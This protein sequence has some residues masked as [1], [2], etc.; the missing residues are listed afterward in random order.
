[1]RRILLGPQHRQRR[2]SCCSAT[3]PPP[4]VPRRGE[5]TGGTGATPDPQHGERR[6]PRGGPVGRARAPAAAP[7]R[8]TTRSPAG[9]RQTQWGP[10]Q[11]QID[12]RR[13]HDHRRRRCC[14][15]P[16]ATRRDQQINAYALPI[17]VAGD[18]GRPERRDR[19]GQRGDGDQRGLPRVAAGAPST[20]HG[21]MTTRGRD[22][23]DSP[24]RR[25]RH[26]HADQPG[27][28]RA[29][30]RRRRRGRRRGP[31][32]DGAARGRPG[33]QHLPAGLGSRGS[34]AARSR[35]DECPPE[36]AEVL[37][38]GDAAERA[39]RRRLRCP[40]GTGRRRAAGASTRAAS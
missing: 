29:P 7:A 28:A 6:R 20:R 4:A 1:M 11:V 16:T 26:G 10:V 37:A 22:R 33:V 35:C 27:A 23:A 5:A 39:V 13:R 15:T 38:L 21:L 34:T 32:D 31:G 8:R 14:S 2:W 19:H 25:A 30:R 12:R 24:V 17:L 9:R 40:A 36:V 3:T 18:A